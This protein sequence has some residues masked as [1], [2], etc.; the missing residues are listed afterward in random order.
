MK[1]WLLLVV[2]VLLAA[3]GE[4][5][6]TQP[7]LRANTPAFAVVTNLSSRQWRLFSVM[8]AT[9][10][11]WDIDP[12][13][14]MSDGVAAFPFQP[15]VAADSGEFAV[16]LE[17]NYN[18]DITGK[19]ITANVSWDPGQFVTRGPAA[20]GAYVRVEFQDVASGNY[21]SNDYWWYS[22]S[23]LDLNAGTGGT[24][25]APLGDRAHWSN[26]CG[27]SA[28][29]E[30]AHPGPN[31]VGGTDPAISPYDGFTNAMKHVK[32]VSLSFGRKSAYASGVAVVGG[33][34]AFTLSSFTIN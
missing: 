24:L 28:T 11:Y 3:C 13:A 12:L 9:S 20:D 21:T 32:V 31:C 30:T 15:F 2:P 10:A 16:Y 25:I 29:D 5:T 18:F 1:R 33:S 14:R 23:A 7:A 22:G 34:S 8:P 17:S 4:A 26:I 6:P 27:K 19:T